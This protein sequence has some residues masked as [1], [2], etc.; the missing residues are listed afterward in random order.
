VPS[1]LDE[2]GPTMINRRRDADPPAALGIRLGGES[3]A[4]EAAE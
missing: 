3:E 4:L 1:I 2:F